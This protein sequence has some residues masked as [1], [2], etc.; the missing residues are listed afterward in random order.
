MK[1]QNSLIE[2]IVGVLIDKL[3]SFISECLKD[4]PAAETQTY[5]P[6]PRDK[7]VKEPLQEEHKK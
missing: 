4:L 7:L 3:P 6:D 5:L 2:R 1:S